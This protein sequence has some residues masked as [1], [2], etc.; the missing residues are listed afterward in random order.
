MC[1]Y[2]PPFVL[3]S[4]STLVDRV[5][6]PAVIIMLIQTA[7]TFVLV[8]TLLTEPNHDKCEIYYN[9]CFADDRKHVLIV[10]S[11]NNVRTTVS[12]DCT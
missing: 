11:I 12:S 9:H 6:F 7:S 10:V 2:S 5:I 8:S 3:Y 1:I 4:L